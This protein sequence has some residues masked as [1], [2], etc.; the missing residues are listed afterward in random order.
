MPKPVLD[1]EVAIIGSG[2]GGQRAAMGLRAE[3]IDDFRMLERRAFL[4][5][6]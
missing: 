1:I 5:G 2:F 3:G 6:T 4:G